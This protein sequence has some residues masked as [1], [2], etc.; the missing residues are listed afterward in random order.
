MCG[1]L[2]S[3]GNFSK[4]KFIKSINLQSHRG[5]DG[6]GFIQYDKFKLGHRRLS[7][8]DLSKS[9]NQPM[10]KYNSNLCISYKDLKR[11]PSDLLILFATTEH[12]GF[13]N[14]FFINKETDR[15][16][17]F[18]IGFFEEISDR[19]KNILF[20]CP[21]ILFPVPIVILSIF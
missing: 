9:A 12:S 20:V 3:Y 4:N 8:I 10:L 19:S 2:G 6:S 18:P 17:F 14:A 7:I 13:F 11:T 16:I 21:N 1:I 5:P 15:F